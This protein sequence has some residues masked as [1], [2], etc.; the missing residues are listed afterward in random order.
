ML[1]ADS[2]QAWMRFYASAGAPFVCGTDRPEELLAEHGWHPTSHSYR[3]LAADL[4]RD[5][6]S[7]A[8]AAPRGAIVTATLAG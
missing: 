6:P 8:A 4:G 5:W 3:D 2:V 7:Q 1:A